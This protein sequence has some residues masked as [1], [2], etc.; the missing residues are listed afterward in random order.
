MQSELVCLTAGF[1]RVLDFCSFI[2]ERVPV[3]V[4][5]FNVDLTYRSAILPPFLSIF[6]LNRTYHVSIIVEA[7]VRI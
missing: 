1:N 2:V 7:L 4:H 6:L 5:P 3:C